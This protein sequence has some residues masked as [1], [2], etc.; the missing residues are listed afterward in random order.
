MSAGSRVPSNDD[1]GVMVESRT[2][3]PTEP[4]PWQLAPVRAGK[5]VR[6][7]GT[8]MSVMDRQNLT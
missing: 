6:S 8:M 5:G 1:A 4:F 2:R 7:A 3:K